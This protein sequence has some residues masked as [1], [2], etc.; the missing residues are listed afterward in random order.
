MK[1][2]APS[3]KCFGRSVGLGDPAKAVRDRLDRSVAKLS[4]QYAELAAYR[5][6][7]GELAKT[8]AEL[9]K[10]AA[11]ADELRDRATALERDKRTA[12]QIPML[13]AVVQDLEA[14]IAALDVPDAAD[15]GERLASAVARLA[16]LTERQRDVLR[17]EAADAVARA[18]RAASELAGLRARTDTAAA[19][20]ARH[21]SESEQLMAA[22]GDTL[23]TLA[24]WSHADLDLAE[25]MR[26]ALP[27]TNGT[28]LENLHSELEGITKRLTGLDEI[29]GPLLTTHARA[30]ERARQ[31]RSY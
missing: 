24:A 25:G 29:L 7:L 3:P 26:E 18:E 23:A 12:E 19:D 4:A 14:D 9:T 20:V 21:E 27:A 30:Y 17:G 13:R 31:I 5:T 6:T 22:H 11:E 8:E 28:V 15:V 1:I 16:A 2:A 10:A